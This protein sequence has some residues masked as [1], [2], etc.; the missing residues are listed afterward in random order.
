M[1]IYPHKLK[2]ALHQC[3]RGQGLWSWGY[4]ATSNQA[5][6]QERYQGSAALDIGERVVTC[7]RPVKRV[8]P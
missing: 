3:R 4:S 2:H 5:R 8:S 6:T 7:C 1:A